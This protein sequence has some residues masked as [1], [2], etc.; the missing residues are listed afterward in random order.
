MHDYEIA[1]LGRMHRLAALFKEVANDSNHCDVSAERLYRASSEDDRL[2]FVKLMIGPFMDAMTFPA[3][4]EAL[5][6][7]EEIDRQ[8]RPNR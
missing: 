3:E 6:K 2:D 7:L 8:H 4:A 5:A 1:Q